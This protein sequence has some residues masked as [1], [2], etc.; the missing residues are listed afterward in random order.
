MYVTLYVTVIIPPP[1]GVSFVFLSR[2]SAAPFA[3]TEF[4]P[5]LMDYSCVCSQPVPFVHV[6]PGATEAPS[7]G[8]HTY[9]KALKDQLR[10]PPHHSTM[11]Q[12]DDVRH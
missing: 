7:R 4:G 10:D 5:V 6:S 1:G 12:N 11:V 3:T 8:I 2:A 9:V